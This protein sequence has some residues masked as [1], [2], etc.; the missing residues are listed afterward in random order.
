MHFHEKYPYLSEG[1]K[2]NT[3]FTHD[4]GIPVYQATIILYHDSSTQT[5]YQC[6]PFSG[7]VWGELTEYQYNE[8]KQF[9]TSSVFSGSVFTEAR[10]NSRKWMDEH[11]INLRNL[12]PTISA[13]LYGYWTY[14]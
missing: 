1:L 8:L 5:Y 13:S 2:N 3:I 14:Y 7:S 11:F 9:N 12:N 4:T 6:W 10:N